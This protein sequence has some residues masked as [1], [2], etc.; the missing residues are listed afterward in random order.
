M[1]FFKKF[2]LLTQVLAIFSVSFV[3]VLVGRIAEL[4][5]LQVQLFT[6]IE[7]PQ[8]A[9]K[10]KAV[11]NTLFSHINV[12]GIYLGGRVPGD[13]A[14]WAA[15]HFDLISGQLYSESSRAELKA[16]NPNIKLCEYSAIPSLNHLDFDYM[17]EWANN[18]DY[19]FEDFFHH[20][21]EDVRDTYWNRNAKGYRE[22]CSP[23]NCDPL[24]T[25]NSIEE[26][27]VWAT[28][29]P[30]PDWRLRKF[31]QQNLE[32]EVYKANRWGAYS[33]EPKPDCLMLDAVPMIDYVTELLALDKTDTYYGI[34]TDSNHPHIEFMF[35]FGGDLTTG[36]NNEYGVDVEPMGNASATF[37][38][39]H[40]HFK[41][42]F[43]NYFDWVW[44]ENWTS[45]KLADGTKELSYERSYENEIALMTRQ[46]LAGEKRLLRGNE[47]YNIPSERGK[48]FILSS[49]YLINNNN[50]YFNYRLAGDP[51]GIGFD[52]PRNQWFEAIAYNIGQPIIN[53]DGKADFNGNYNTVEHYEWANGADPA[54]PTKTYHIMARNYANAL[55]LVKYRP[56]NSTMFDASVTVHQLDQTYTPL[57]SDGTLG[58]PI[59]S[60]SLRNNEAAILIPYDDLVPVAVDDLRGGADDTNTINL[61]WTAPSDN[62]G[63]VS[64]YELRYSENEINA[65]NWGQAELLTGLSNP[66]M[67]GFYES[68]TV[69]NLTANTQYYFA[70]KSVDDN[71]NWSAISNIAE[72]NTDIDYCNPNWIC[73]LWSSCQNNIQTRT[74]SDS[75]ECGDDTGRPELTQSCEE[76]VDTCISNW[77]C[78]DW[79]ECSNNQQTRACTDLNNCETFISPITAKECTEVIEED[80]SFLASVG[81]SAVYYISS[82]EK[83][84]VFPDQKTYMTWYS[85][86]NNIITLSIAQLDQYPDGGA[87][88]YRPGTKLITHP[89]TARIYAVS[90]GGILHW[91]PNEATAVNLYGSQWYTRVQDVIPGFFSASYT[92]GDSLSD[93]L[94]DGAIVYYKSSRYLVHSG[95]RRRFTTN[96]AFLINNFSDFYLISTDLNNYPEG[97]PVTGEEIFI[98]RFK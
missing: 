28:W 68:F 53:P 14:R 17:E 21:L 8:I 1:N 31:N 63:Q 69:N 97:S 11:S 88:T 54:D 44:V 61:Y 84:Y 82:N 29:Y 87:V 41:E 70:I 89:N 91:I 98:S 18:N 85:N 27:R 51:E 80:S 74:C 60:I 3:L 32:F 50:A 36:L 25:A 20:Y 38:L 35:Q 6:Y 42:R 33:N 23:D 5:L 7:P 96:N 22:E 93:K 64:A 10:V 72:V 24:A 77:S 59:N 19:D 65:S 16:I 52:N 67:P 47:P 37:F 57:N 39:A 34:P 79:S 13:D 73:S 81:G 71:D 76:A 40:D 56:Y 12:W 78:T 55:V 9:I 83:K 45:Y 2:K 94:P 95:Q 4:G 58:S 48:T 75:N 26:A 92:I 43:V 66:G 49:F 15:S 86:F 62:Q 30:R 46:T 90:P